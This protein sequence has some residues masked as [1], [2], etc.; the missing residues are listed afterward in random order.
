MTA[1]VDE[2][3]RRTSSTYDIRNR[4]TS[5]T[6]AL[7]QT[8]TYVYDATDNMMTMSTYSAVACSTNSMTS[9]AS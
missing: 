5:L 7:G 9:T 3:G 2:L 1:L 8:E 4:H 6:D